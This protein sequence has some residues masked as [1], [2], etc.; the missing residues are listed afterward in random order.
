MFKLSE[1]KRLK[2]NW[3]K[4]EKVVRDW[5][6]FVNFKQVSASCKNEHYLYVQWIILYHSYVVVK[7]EFI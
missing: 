3:V 2:Q 7:K 6:F 4:S 5:D 1:K